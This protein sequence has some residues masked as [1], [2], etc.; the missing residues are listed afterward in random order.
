[1]IA[2]TTY[3]EVSGDITETTCLQTVKIKG[4]LGD[5]RKAPNLIGLSSQA[6]HTMFLLMDM[7]KILF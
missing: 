4:F 3:E 1:M 5:D 6:K 2:T 7:G